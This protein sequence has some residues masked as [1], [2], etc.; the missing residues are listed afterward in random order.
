V[1]DKG[2][3]I[4]YHDENLSL[5]DI[6][7]RIGSDKA[8]VHRNIKRFRETG[9][10][11][12]KT[13]SGRKRKISDAEVDHMILSIKRDRNI[14]LNELKQDLDDTSVHN[15]TISRALGRNGRVKNV[16]QTKKPFV[17]KK[18][19]NKR[20]KWCRERINW[21]V[22]EWK[23]VLWSD[24]SPFV[25]RFNQKERVWKLMDEK[26][27]PSLLTGTVKHDDKIMVWGC[28]SWY[29]TG[30]LYKIRGT[31][32]KMQ[33]KNIIQRQ[34]LTSAEELYPDGDYIFQQ[35]ND[36]KHTSK[37]VK[38][39]LE[40]KNVNVLH[41]PAQSPDLNPIE[42]LW[43][44]LDKMAKDRRPQTDD[45]LFEILEDTWKSIPITYL[46]NL[47]ESMP[48]RCQAVLDNDGLPTKY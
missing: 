45:Q 6:A 28:F 39:Y 32:E 16:W 31:M 18:N 30:R 37:V 34:M 26:F 46:K 21:T 47:V 48:R 27:H 14:S 2:Q 4:A 10:Y 5:K 35:D 15:S 23:K 20:K 44:I 1:F 40:Y 9:E 29:G 33:Y 41:W 19:Q 8:T 17:S 43:S 38:R 12:R 24:E 11:A 7:D 13:G 22:D 3:I 42:N 25:F 36:P